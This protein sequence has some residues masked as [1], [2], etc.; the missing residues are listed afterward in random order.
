MFNNRVQNGK[1]EFQ[2]FMEGSDKLLKL[3]VEKNIYCDYAFFI[4]TANQDEIMD[5]ISSISQNINGISIKY[6]MIE[7]KAGN[8]TK[9]ILNMMFE[10]VSKVPKVCFLNLASFLAHTKEILDR[11]AIDVPKEFSMT[12]SFFTKRLEKYNTVLVKYLNNDETVEYKEKM[13][14]KNFCKYTK[15]VN[16]NIDTFKNLI[17]LKGYTG[18]VD[19]LGFIETFYEIANN[20]VQFNNE[21]VYNI[22]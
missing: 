21:I 15:H 9:V 20:M 19:G 22:K 8:N 5:V 3:G 12:I 13:L 17:I 18:N 7:E 2:K 16:Y 10:N 6:N 14:P 4:E 1:S 11:Y